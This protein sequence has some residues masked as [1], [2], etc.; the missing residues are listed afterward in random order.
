MVTQS[1]DPNNKSKPAYKKYCSYCH[2]NNHG[3]SNCYQKQRDEEYQRYKNQ[4]SRLLNSPFYNMSAVNLVIHKK[5][6][7]KTKM[8][9]FLDN[10]HTRS[11]QNT[12]PITTTDIDIKTDIEVIVEIIHKIITD[13]TLDKDIT[14]DL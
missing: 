6:E 13:L 10:D 7:M 14:I 11:N 4:R 8:I 9:I 5:I 3:I 1:G 12:T 2:K